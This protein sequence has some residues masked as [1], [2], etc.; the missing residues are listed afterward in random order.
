MRGRTKHRCS[1]PQVLWKQHDLLK[2]GGNGL[3]GGDKQYGIGGGRRKN[4]G[5]ANEEVFAFGS[6][7]RK[8]EKLYSNKE[9][10]RII[11]R[12][13][14]TGKKRD[15]SRM[16]KVSVASLGILYLRE[17]QSEEAEKGGREEKERF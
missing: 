2:S 12:L 5:N 14:K 15:H 16:Q 4:S 10:G 7:H 1:V 9:G 3:G 17:K 8:L 11:I 13:G 6:F